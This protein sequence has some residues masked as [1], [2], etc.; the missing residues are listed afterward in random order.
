M[1]I[2]NSSL[3]NSIVK[4]A[5]SPTQYDGK[6]YSYKYWSLKN[7]ITISSTSEFKSGDVV[8]I[9]SID[10]K[11]NEVIVEPVTNSYDK[12]NS[13]LICT[14]N[15]VPLSDIDIYKFWYHGCDL[16]LS[17][18][19]KTEGN[20]IYSFLVLAH[21]DIAQIKGYCRDSNTRIS[22]QIFNK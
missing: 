9:V 18:E 3:I 6:R 17:C 7:V 16:L 19:S 5:Y 14:S 11:N 21:T 22:F 2:L 12:V 13:I 4:I 20:K 15:D 8:R 1:E 10:Y